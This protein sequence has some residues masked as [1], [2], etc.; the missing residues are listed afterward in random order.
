MTRQ[1]T[2]S[3]MHQVTLLDVNKNSA[4][5][6]KCEVSADVPNFQTKSGVGEMKVLSEYSA[7][8]VSSLLSPPH[9]LTPSPSLSLPLHDQNSA[10]IKKF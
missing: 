8:F 5:K 3:N 1:L 2:A 6:Y 9:P 7:P 10:K 4:G